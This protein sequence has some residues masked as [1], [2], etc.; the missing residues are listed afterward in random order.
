MTRDQLTDVGN[1][2][3]QNGKETDMTSFFEECVADLSKPD[4]WDDI[5]SGNDVC[6]S[7]SYKGWHVMI[8]HPDPKQRELGEEMQRFGVQRV[9]DSGYAITEFATTFD[10]D[11]WSEVVAFVSDEE[12]LHLAARNLM[13]RLSQEGWE[14]LSLD[15]W[16]SE[17]GDKLD[18]YDREVA[19]ELL[20]EFD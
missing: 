10:C 17:Y 18:Q 7:W 6:P 1:R 3:T 2:P 19:Y 15:E 11:W 16:I 20:R 9:T 5:S 4:G 12:N 14:K 8:D 13:A